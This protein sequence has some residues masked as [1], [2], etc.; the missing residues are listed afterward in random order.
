MCGDVDGRLNLLYKRVRN[1]NNK[2]GP[3][4]ILIC[5]GDFFNTSHMEEWLT[6][7]S[8]KEKSKFCV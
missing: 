2:N 3:F 8:G 4:D 7:Q 6:Y 5:V 1:V